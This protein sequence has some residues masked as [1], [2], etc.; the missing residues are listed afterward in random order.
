MDVTDKANLEGISEY[1]VFRIAYRSTFP[2]RPDRPDEVESD[3][4]YYLNTGEIPG[5]VSYY[6]N[7]VE[8]EA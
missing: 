2:D 1:D 3:F 6:L 7:G 5:Y 8:L 4:G